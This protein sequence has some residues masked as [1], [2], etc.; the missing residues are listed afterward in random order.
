MPEQPSQQKTQ[1]Q[2]TELPPRLPFVIA[3]A[4][5]D[6]STDKDSRLVNCF[7]EKTD[8]GEYF[9]YKRPGLAVNTTKS[10]NGLGCYNWLG[11]IYALFGTDIYKNGVSIGTV[12]A[13]NGVYRFSASIGGTPRLML[14]NGTAGYTYDGTT[15]AIIP[16]GDYPSPVVKGVA[17]LDATTYVMN[18]IAEI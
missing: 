6:E 8:T 12:D 11:D 3:P 2:T 18:S 4:N 9:V 17:W 14:D 15:F 5:R 7:V 10:G 1:S 16:D 13:T